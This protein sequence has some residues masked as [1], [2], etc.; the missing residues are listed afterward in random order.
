ML[1]P[2]DHDFHP[3]VNFFENSMK[4]QSSSKEQDDLADLII[5]RLK[6]ELFKAEAKNMSFL[7]PIPQAKDKLTLFM[8]PA[9]RELDVSSID[10]DLQSR[11]PTHR[12][13]E[14]ISIIFSYC[15]DGTIHYSAALSQ[16]LCSVITSYSNKIKL[17][18]EGDFNN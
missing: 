4:E 11:N 14:V 7:L 15:K 10:I 16:A 3:F 13:L 6:G 8:I 1:F 2:I 17:L 9:H 5:F 12:E 18:T